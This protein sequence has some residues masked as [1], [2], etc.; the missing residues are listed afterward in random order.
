MPSAPSQP[1]LQ[2]PSRDAPSYP[3]SSIFCYLSL[4]TAFMRMRPEKCNTTKGS[5][6]P[7]SKCAKESVVVMNPRKG[8]PGG[9]PCRGFASSG[10]RKRTEN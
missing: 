10:R 2:E 7:G 5:G 1:F 6:I 3:R 4:E 9:F 8:P